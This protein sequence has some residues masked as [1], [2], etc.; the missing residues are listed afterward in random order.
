MTSI[1]PKKLFAITVAKKTWTS[2]VPYLVVSIPWDQFCAK[3]GP[4]AYAKLVEAMEARAVIVSKSPKGKWATST[5]WEKEWEFMA[6]ADPLESLEWHTMPV[7][8][9]HYPWELFTR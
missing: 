4:E 7:E 6:G 8:S 1:P 3:G 9:D 5:K 2:A